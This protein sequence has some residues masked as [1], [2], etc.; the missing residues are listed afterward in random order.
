MLDALKFVRGAIARKDLVA[1]LSHFR[2]SGGR[3]KGYNGK[4]A[5]CCPLPL[6]LDV[7]PKAEPFVKAIATCEQ[8]VAI[9]RKSVV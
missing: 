1:A 9:D 6:D 2:I 5:L 4:I 3:I 8:T 7:M